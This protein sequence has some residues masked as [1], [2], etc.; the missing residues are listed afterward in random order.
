MQSLESGDF[1][2]LS[3]VVSV[4][5]AFI[6]TGQDMKRAAGREAENMIIAIIEGHYF[7]D[8]QVFSQANQGGIGVIRGGIMI[9]STSEV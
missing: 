9:L 2:F 6:R 4:S 8:F 5:K 3:S 1:M 7:P